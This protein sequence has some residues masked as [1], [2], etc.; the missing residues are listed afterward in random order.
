MIKIK[1]WKQEG[2]NAI[3]G[4]QWRELKGWKVMTWFDHEVNWPSDP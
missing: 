1:T 3:L 4:C 2:N